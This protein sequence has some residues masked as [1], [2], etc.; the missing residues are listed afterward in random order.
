VEIIE[1]YYLTID[2]FKY[3]DGIE[4]YDLEKYVRD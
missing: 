3:F 2:D 4:S 1:R